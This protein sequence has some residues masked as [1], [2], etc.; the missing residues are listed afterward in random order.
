MIPPTGSICRRIE[1][2]KFGLR[3]GAW[4]SA[5][6]RISR[7][8]SSIDRPCRAARRRSRA[9]VASSSLRIVMLAMIHRGSG[10][11]MCHPSMCADGTGLSP[12][13]GTIVPE[14]W[15]RLLERKSLSRCVG[16]DRSGCFRSCSGNLSE[17]GFWGLSRRGIELLSSSVSRA[18]GRGQGMAFVFST[19]S[20]SCD[21]ETKFLLH[22]DR[23]RALQQLRG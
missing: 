12:F 15:D 22:C 4:L 19:I 9:V 14:S 13:S 10:F 2:A 23:M 5:L 8:S 6:V 17:L 18:G 3:A 20:H 21:W 1:S 16:N 11:N 7:A